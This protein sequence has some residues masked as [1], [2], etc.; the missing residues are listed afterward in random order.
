MSSITIRP[1]HSREVPRELL[2][3]ADPS[4]AMVDSYL[5]R[6]R[7]FV[8]EADERIVGEMILLDTRPYTMELVNLAVEEAWQNR[9]VGTALVQFAIAY[10][11]GQQVRTLEL[12]TGNSGIAQMALYQK[13]GFRIVGVDLDFFTRNYVQPIYEDGIWC[14][15]MVRMAIDLD[16]LWD[17]ATG[18][19]RE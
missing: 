6:G 3:L 11:R 10:A 13:C 17:S 5:H 1:A 4:D 16:R 9:G 12:G 7:C 19:Y 18:E 2:L 15:D 8:A 14:R